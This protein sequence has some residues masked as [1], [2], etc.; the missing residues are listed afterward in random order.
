MKYYLENRETVL[1]ELKTSDLGLSSSEAAA[2]LQQ[3]GKNRLKEE[4]KRSV[5]RKFLDSVMHS[6]DVCCR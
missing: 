5:W 6:S 2:R 3:N 1:R 4:E